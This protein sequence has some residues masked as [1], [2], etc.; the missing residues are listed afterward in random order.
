MHSHDPKP[1]ETIKLSERDKSRLLRAVE[2]QSA[3]QGSGG[4]GERRHLR[5]AYHGRSVLITMNPMGAN[6]RYSVVPRNLSRG[7]LAFIHGRFIYPQTA[8]TVSLGANDGQVLSVEARVLRCRHIGGIMHE[9]SLQFEEPIDLEQFVPLSPEQAEAHSQE[10]AEHEADK[11]VHLEDGANARVL[12][13]DDFAADRKLLGLHLRKQGMTV[14]DAEDRA[15]GLR[16]LERETYDLAVI[17]LNLGREDGLELVRQL[18][19]NGFAA[20]LIAVSADDTEQLQARAMEAGANAFLAKPFRGE[21]LGQMVAQLLSIHAAGG[22]DAIRSELA[23]DRTM[24]PLVR[25]FVAGLSESIERLRDAG[26]ADDVDTVREVCQQLKGA[27]TS[28]GFEAITST[29]AV[30]LES[31]DSD[32]QEVEQ[33]RSSVNDLLALLRRVEFV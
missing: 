7:G 22:A 26:P 19:A 14:V 15:A 29:A 20:P 33:V 25:E 6:V 31:I 16:M 12:L 8:C 21:Q 3:Q 2:A 17:D 28:Y 13:V 11:P 10:R 32:T 30:V 1:I 24:R 5:V 9:V 23:E 27:G 4:H 18:R